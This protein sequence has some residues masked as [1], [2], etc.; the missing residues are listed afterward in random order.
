MTRRLEVFAIAELST[1]GEV[2]LKGVASSS[3]GL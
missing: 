2:T 3:G 1:L